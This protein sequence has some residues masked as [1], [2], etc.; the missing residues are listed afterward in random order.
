MEHL[1]PLPAMNSGASGQRRH[2]SDSFSALRA[3][4]LAGFFTAALAAYNFCQPL[5]TAVGRWSLLIVL[6]A[7]WYIG[8]TAVAGAAG[9]WASSLF[10]RAGSSF[11]PAWLSAKFSVGWVFL[12]CVA[13]LYHEH[14]ALMLLFVT[15]SVLA[16]ALTLRAIHPAHESMLATPYCLAAELSSFN[17]LPPVESHFASSLW[18]VMCIQATVY[19]GFADKLFLASLPLAAAIFLLTWRWSVSDPASARRLTGRIPRATLVAI[20]AFFTVFVLLPPFPGSRSAFSLGSTARKPT[21]TRHAVDNDSSGYVGIILWPPTKK[22][23]EITLPSHDPSLRAGAIT[24]AVRIPFDGPYWYF[25]SPYMEPGLHAH[26]ARA[27]PTE[28]NIRSTDFRPMRM[29]AHQNLSQPVTLDC[30]SAI[31][32]AVT[33]ADNRPGAITVAL[34]LA[35]SHSPGSIPLY[36]PSLPIASSQSLTATTNRPPVRETLRF[37][38]PRSTTLHRFDQITVVLT[39]APARARLA[40]RVSIQGFELLP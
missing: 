24:Q 14:S 17:G 11:S 29:E 35:D 5:H 12:P 19:F 26:L 18:F 36:I 28:V 39:A 8:L 13:L 22:K 32:V 34:R 7:A 1:Q 30:C 27:Q 21:D 37:T 3:L 4:G 9:V 33:N 10:F 38:I 25:R 40:P 23:V 20:A 6:R 31:N 16:I 15:L 2:G